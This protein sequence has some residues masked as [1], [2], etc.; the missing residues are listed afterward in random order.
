MK[1]AWGYIALFFA[2]VAAGIV[3]G[4][5]IMGDQIS[6]TVK[7]IKQKRTSGESDIS[8]PIN[9][10]N[11]NLGIQTKRGDRKQSRIEKRNDRKLKKDLR[12]L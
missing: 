2:G 5:K 3:V 11:A 12:K 8:I 9:L 10:D 6:I 7:K 4:V 1:K